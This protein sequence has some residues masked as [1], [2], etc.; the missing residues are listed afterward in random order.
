MIIA[1]DYCTSRGYIQ[2]PTLP[3]LPVCFRYFQ[4][5]PMDA[6]SASNHCEESSAT[7]LQ[8]LNLDTILHIGAYLKK[9]N[10]KVALLITIQIITY[11]SCYGVQTY[12][13]PLADIPFPNFAKK[14]R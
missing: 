2:T 11:K 3:Q 4:L 1:T 13:G 12:T 7:L 10:G 8:I 14:M 5:T 6:L 9:I